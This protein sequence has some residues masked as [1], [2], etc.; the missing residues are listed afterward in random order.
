[1]DAERKRRYHLMIVYVVTEACGRG[2]MYRWTYPLEHLDFGVKIIVL[3]G[4]RGPDNIDSMILG[5]E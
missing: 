3:R 5:L 2:C 1:M 4:I